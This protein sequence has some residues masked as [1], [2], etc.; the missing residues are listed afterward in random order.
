L[1]SKLGIVDCEAEKRKEGEGRE[2]RAMQREAEANHRR[3]YRDA[4][5]LEGRAVARH[6]GDQ[7][8]KHFQVLDAKLG[9]FLWWH[10]H[11]TRTGSKIA[12]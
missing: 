7:A 6:A 3:H 5:V 10:T 2:D 12:M 4:V 8:L 1:I 11:S 9:Y